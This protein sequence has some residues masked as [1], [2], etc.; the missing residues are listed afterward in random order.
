MNAQRCIAFL[1]QT[2]DFL[3]EEFRSKLG[4]RVYCDTCQ[5]VCPKNQKVD[6]HHHPEFEPEDDIAK[7]LLKPMLTI[8]NREFKE[9][10]G[11]ISG[12]WRGKNRFNEMRSLDLVIIRIK[13]Q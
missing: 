5:L 9:Q 12:S 4:N 8:S 2:K 1:T 11:H 6:F 7:P 3:P 10:F 13:R